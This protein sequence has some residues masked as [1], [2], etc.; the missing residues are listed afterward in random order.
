MSLVLCIDPGTVALGVSLIEYG[1][2]KDPKIIGSMTIK[3]IAYTMDGVKEAGRLINAAW[4]RGTDRKWMHIDVIVEMIAPRYYGRSNQV[5]LIKISWQVLHFFMYFQKKVRGIFA[6]DSFEW[7][8]KMLGKVQSQ[9]TDTEKKELF[10]L[11]FPTFSEGRAKT[12]LWGSKDTRDASL[13][14]YWWI[15]QQENK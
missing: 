15:K 14:G 5:A 9:Y 8:K 1:E 4:I 6:I 2:G 10:K 12:S 13:M 3:K 7:N 11:A